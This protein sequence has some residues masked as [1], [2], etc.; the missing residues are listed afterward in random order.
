MMATDTDETRGLRSLAG[1][2]GN[3]APGPLPGEMTAA[4]VLAAAG[5]PATKDDESVFFYDLFIAAADIPKEPREIPH[6][7]WQAALKYRTLTDQE[8][9]ARERYFQRKIRESIRKQFAAQ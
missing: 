6:R 3:S 5:L 4:E 2:S 8:Q 9:A 1:A 7:Q